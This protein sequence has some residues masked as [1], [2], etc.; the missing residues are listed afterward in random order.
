MA[1]MYWGS[2]F[3]TWQHKGCDSSRSTEQPKES[4][5]AP[6]RGEL[7]CCAKSWELL[8]VG[9]VAATSGFLAGPN[10]TASLYVRRPRIRHLPA[11]KQ[12]SVLPREHLHLSS[13]HIY[14]IFGWPIRASR[15][16]LCFFHSSSKVL[17]SSVIE[18]WN[19]YSRLCSTSLRTVRC[20]LGLDWIS[21][22]GAKFEALVKFPFSE[23]ESSLCE[24]PAGE[25]DPRRKVS[26][27]NPL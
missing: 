4:V 24:N 26:Q 22:E 19:V 7:A 21:L 27:I 13:Q 5:L 18:S 3:I 20:L 14:Y 10:K 17:L 12:K 6:Q 2:T 25:R 9:S 11:C 15:K 23:S 1:V 8:C 16:V